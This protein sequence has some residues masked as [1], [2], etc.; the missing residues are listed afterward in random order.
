MEKIKVKIKGK[1]YEVEKGT[2]LGK[3]FE[4]AGIKDALGGVINGKIID[5]QT[6]VRE[7]GEIKPV[8]RGSKESLEIMRHSLA[9]IMAQAL[10]ELYGAKKVHLGVGPTTEEGFYYDVEVE[11]HKITE[12]DLPKIEQKMKEII[13]RD[14]PILRRELSREEAIKLFDKLKEK[15]KIDIIKEIPEE[16][17][18]SVYEQGDFIDLCKGPHLPSTG[19]AGAFKLTSISGAYWKGRSDQPQL[20]RIYGIAYWSDKEVKE[21]LKFYEEVKKRDHRRLGKELEFFTIDDNVGAGLILWLPRGA[22]Y[23]KVLE[24]YLREEHLKRGYQLVYTPHVGKS[25]LWETS[26]HLECYKQNMFPSMKIDE[27]EYYVKPMNCPFHIAIY[28]SRTRSYKELPLKLFELGTVYRYELS[29]VLHGLL[30]VRGFTQDDAHIVCTPEQVNDVIRETLDFALSTLKDF[31]FNEFKIYLS[32]R[33]EYSIGSDEQWEVSQNALKKAIEDL[34]YEYEIDEGGGAFY[35]PKIDVKIR[36]AIG[37][38]WQLSTI[39]FDF[40]LPERFDMTYVGPDNKKH[41]PYMIHRALLGSIERFTGI[42]LE[43]YAGLLPIWL[44]PTQ[45]MIIPIAD[46][47]HEYAKKVYEFLKENGIRAEMDL[48]EERMN[49]KIRD[50]ELKKIPVILVVGDREAQN[51][52]VSVRTKKEGNLGSMELNKFLDWIKEKIKN[53][54]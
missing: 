27:E 7:S 39:Q 45:V 10:K 16:E 29:G 42:L 48:R 19:K 18:I 37:R 12:E 33:P 51:N 36:D 50:A 47:H 22:I 5:L 35:G 25:K 1:E 26:G 13:E 31:G 53:K 17:V 54:E 21:R 38:M 11:G 24:D 52:T 15:Y 30:R 46:R 34:G 8:Y 20:T 41:R 32:T 49:A 44:S 4:L 9:H 43:H 2:P 3:I 40:N 28:K 14:Y 6:P 23:R